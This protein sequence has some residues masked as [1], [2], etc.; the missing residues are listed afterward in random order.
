MPRRTQKKSAATKT[1]TKKTDSAPPHDEI[2]HEAFKLYQ[3][4]HGAPGDPVADWFEATRIVLA[5]RSGGMP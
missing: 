5:E 1:T 4:R 2:A 3:S